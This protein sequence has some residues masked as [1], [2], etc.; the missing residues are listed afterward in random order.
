GSAA[1]TSP[2]CA[3]ATCRAGAS[4]TSW[5]TSTRTSSRRGGTG[6]G[7]RGRTSS[8][9]AACART[10][11][12]PTPRA[13]AEARGTERSHSTSQRPRQ[14]MAVSSSTLSTMTGTLRTCTATNWIICC[15]PGNPRPR[16]HGRS[17]ARL[18]RSR[19]CRPP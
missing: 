5:S 15:C 10:S 19:T 4:R 11:A 8:W 6:R 12:P 2:R 18:T 16:K 13:A 3:A 9:A 17:G 1:G 14:L 7:R